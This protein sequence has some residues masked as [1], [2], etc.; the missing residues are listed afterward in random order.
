MQRLPDEGGLG[1]VA[2]YLRAVRH[3]AYIAVSAT[4]ALD[5]GIARHPGDA[6]AQAKDAIRSALS[7]A[8]ELGATR[9]SV[10]RTRLLLGPGCDWKA[11][12]DAHREIFEG[13]P[14]ANTTYYVGGLIPEGAL[15]EV[16]LDAIAGD[17]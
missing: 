11:V 17:Q 1:T 10:L 2:A 3:G 7:A 14:P 12:I 8:T 6:H 9:E 13:A 16:E 4:A 5:G 15:V